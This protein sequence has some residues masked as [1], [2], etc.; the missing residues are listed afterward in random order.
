[1]MEIKPA[2]DFVNEKEDGEVKK[3]ILLWDDEGGPAK[4][5]SEMPTLVPCHVDYW[6]KTMEVQL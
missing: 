6:F 4:K 2:G 1:M 3:D 5:P